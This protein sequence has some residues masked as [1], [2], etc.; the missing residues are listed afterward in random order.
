[1]GAKKTGP[2][3]KG[4][5]VTTSITLH[6]A[7]YSMAQDVMEKEGYSNFSAF[8]ADL[9]RRRK[10]QVAHNPS[11]QNVKSKLAEIVNPPKAKPNRE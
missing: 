4:K 10:E 7:A 6:H 9:I 2:H 5:L 1:M 8:V 3:R 11:V